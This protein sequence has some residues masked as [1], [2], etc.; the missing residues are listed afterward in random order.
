M[1]ST[2]Y[3]P[4]G[5]QATI[6]LGLHPNERVVHWN[7]LGHIFCTIALI[8]SPYLYTRVFTITIIKQLKKLCYLKEYL[9]FLYFRQQSQSLQVG[10]PYLHKTSHD[11]QI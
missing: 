5:V 3:M 4:L 8:A 1:Q 10:L 7:S 11:H 2:K 6:S 9:L